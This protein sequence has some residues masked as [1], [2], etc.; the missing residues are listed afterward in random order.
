MALITKD[1]MVERFGQAELAQIT[2]H[3]NGAEIDDA[4]LNLALNDASD[5]AQS[6]LRGAGIIIVNPPKALVL[7]VCDI[8]RYYLYENAVTEIVEKRYQQAI[9]WLKTVQ[10]NPAML[11]DDPALSDDSLNGGIAVKPN[12]MPNW[13]DFQ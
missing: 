5:E 12:E 4:V 13:K 7:K 1:D 3:K 6:Y 9:L 2:D 10:K 8:A 11:R